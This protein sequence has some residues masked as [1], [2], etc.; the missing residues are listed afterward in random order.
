MLKYTV[1][2]KSP[3]REVVS[4]DSEI[5]YLGKSASMIFWGLWVLLAIKM[6]FTK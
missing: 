1:E 4:Y 2:F 3:V 6:L 5:D